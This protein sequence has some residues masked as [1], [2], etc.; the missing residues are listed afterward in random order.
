VPEGD[1]LHR[2]ANALQVLV[3]L[4]VRALLLPRQG[5]GHSVA[6]DTVTEV[7]AV[8]KN[9]LV[10]FSGG[11][12]LHTHLKM[13][14]LW[15]VYAPGERWRRSTWSAVAIID[16]GDA[17]AVCFQAPLVR[18]IERRRAEREIVLPLASIDL[19]AAQADIGEVMRRL[20]ALP[21]TM[22]VGVALMDQEC[23][24][25]VGNVFKSE[26]LFRARIHPHAIMGSIDDD[27]LHALLQDLQT[28][29][30][31][32][33]GQR[34]AGP[35]DAV[36]QYRYT[37]TTTTTDIQAP[38]AVYGRAGQPCFVCGGAIARVRQGPQQRSS[39]FCPHCQPIC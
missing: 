15:H 34:A 9:L 6:G 25:G 39:Y 17:I 24:G 8:G 33:V 31:D 12:V 21:A 26:G 38:L 3:P 23:V 19:I 4:T 22:P 11:L 5:L 2:I 10:F 18:L 36:A 16:V 14:G 1:T 20:R 13:T 27:R 28:I 29:M 30:R 37:R 35:A 7:R 32:N